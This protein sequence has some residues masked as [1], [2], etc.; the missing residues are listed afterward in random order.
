MSEIQPSSQAPGTLAASAD[1]TLSA[2]QPDV[3]L[4]T[5]HSAVGADQRMLSVLVVFLGAGLFM[6]LPFVLSIGAVVF[7]PLASAIILSIVLAPVADRMARLGIPNAL[8]SLLALLLAA[9]IFAGLLTLIVQP[10]LATFDQLPEMAQQVSQKVSTL[11]SSLGWVNDLNRQIAKVGGH[12]QAREVVLV[13]PSMIEQIAIATPAVVLEMLV[14][15]LMSYFLIESRVRMRRRLLNDRTPS[16]VGLKAARLARE[17][18]DLVASYILTVGMINLG[19]GVLVTF[20][21]WALGLQAPIMWGGMAA[22][23]NFLPYLGPLAIV[24]LLALFGLGTA[25]TLFSGLLPAALYLGLH[26][27]EANVITPAVLGRRFTLNPVMI[28]LSISYFYWIWGVTGA[29]LSVPIL[30]VLTALFHHVGK[31]NLIGFIFGDPLFPAA[32]SIL[33]SERSD[34]QT[35][36]AAEESAG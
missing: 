27:V 24:A 5:P 17:V 26:A 9:T 12:A 35:A 1:R 25:P 20:G 28:L 16:H 3:P 10:A 30:L 14:T 4:L 15:I 22:L 34:N 36:A 8:A 23:L 2:S 7:L 11:R 18:Q 13:G 19:I 33:P 21:A 31:P 29:L 6:A 32:E